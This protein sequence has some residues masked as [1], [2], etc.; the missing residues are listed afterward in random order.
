MRIISLDV[1]EKRIGVARADS[2]VRIAVPVTTIEVNGTEFDE[3]AR[4]MKLYSTNFAVLGLPR[5]NEGNETAQS[6]YVRNFA[7]TLGEKIPDIKI[8][9]QDESL[10]SVEA[11][12]RLKARKKSYEKGEIDAE[13]AAIILQDFIESFEEKKPQS[14]TTTIVERSTEKA[15]LNSKKVTDGS[16]K[17]IKKSAKLVTNE[18]KKVVKKSRHVMRKFFILIPVLA[19]LGLG[20]LGAFFWYQDQL[21]PAIEVC[22]EDYCPD[23]EFVI[24]EGDTKDII[25]NHLADQG[26][27]KNSF[28]FKI[29]TKLNNGG[30]TF[31]T[32]TYNLNP[33]MEPKEIIEALI[34]GSKNS[35]VFSFTILPGENIFSI[36]KKLI[37]AGFSY[38]EVTEAFQDPFEYANYK[39]KSASV[40]GYLL[41]ETYEFYKGT[42]VKQILERFM[43]GMDEIINNNNLPARLAEKGL[44]VHEAI[45]LASIVQK[46]AR[47]T[48]P[49]VANEEQK[50]VA[51]IFLKRLRTGMNLGSDVT[52]SYAIDAIDPERKRYDNNADAL[53]VESCYNTRNRAGLPCGP[54]SSPSL[55]ALLAVTEPSDTDYLFFLTGD[56]GKMY[57][58]Y[59][60]AEHNQNIYD[61]CKV[62][63]NV[64]L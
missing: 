4:I 10:T 57:Y 46:E 42:T 16:K 63:C 1:G 47:M 40:E 37:E 56:D 25:A 28:A 19:V 52:V 59:T 61:H 58:S 8:R 53:A 38:E 29:Y 34:K 45:I 36:Q 6:V 23:I 27:I 31:K 51:Q 55:S 60:D 50:T 64:S 26:L 33:H 22:P 39:P 9:F 54:I 30:D 18:S 2:S 24:N 41:G 49:N 32:G 14:K 43:N 11:E 17:I 44:S 3:I 12:K 15:A 5:S 35:D 7:R 21:K 20:A 13:A 48:D 62:L